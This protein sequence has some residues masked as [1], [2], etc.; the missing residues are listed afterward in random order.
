[1]RF[2]SEEICVLLISNITWTYKF[3]RIRVTPPKSC[4]L[5]GDRARASPASKWLLRLLFLNVLTTLS[6]SDWL[7]CTVFFEDVN[8]FWCSPVFDCWFHSLSKP[9]K[10]RLKALK[11][12]QFEAILLESNFFQEL[13]MLENKY[14]E[15]RIP[16]NEKV[17]YN[18]M[19]FITFW[20]LES[21]ADYKNALLEHCRKTIFSPGSW[22][23][24]F[25][26]HVSGT[27]DG[28]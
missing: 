10:R 15:M 16:L 14:E 28:R 26:K 18:I 12:L 19:F 11:K 20:L 13:Q 6:A 4:L 5:A 17:G 1:M 22:N 3:L 24:I 23:A 7:N 25:G 27:D 21:Y 9:V 2:A 8:S